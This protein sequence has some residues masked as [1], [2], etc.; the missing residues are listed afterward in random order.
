[1][2]AGNQLL[3]RRAHS[4]RMHAA[5][6][7]FRKRARPRLLVVEEAP[8]PQPAAD[9]TR[10]RVE[11]SGVNLADVMGISRSLAIGQP[12]RSTAVGSLCRR[13]RMGLPEVLR[14]GGRAPS[15]RGYRHQER[16]CVAWGGRVRSATLVSLA[17]K[18]D[19]NAMGDFVL[20]QPPPG[21]GDTQVP[22][23][24]SRGR[25]RVRAFQGRL[26]L[27]LFVGKATA[28]AGRRWRIRCPHLEG[29]RRAAR[30]QRN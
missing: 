22:S 4:L 29:P 19:R 15:A 24:R 12:R 18:A 23:Y 16:D 13:R 9:E 28:T 8:D 27:D 5:D 25:A 7:D 26:A 3:P 30:V 11:P 6:L 21:D 20:P 17:V 1:M 10:I 14:R 2:S